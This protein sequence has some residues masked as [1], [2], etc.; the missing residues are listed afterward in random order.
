MRLNKVKKLYG[1]EFLK[2]IEY[3]AGT[4]FVEDFKKTYYWQKVRTAIFDEDFY[5][6]DY[7][8]NK[9][10]LRLTFSLYLICILLFHL[11]A[12]IKWMFTGSYNYDEKSFFVKKM[13][14]W[15]RYC[16]FNII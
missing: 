7:P 4:Q 14:V 10:K 6:R 8:K 2:K 9:P 3:S 13:I 11:F 16:R 5:I 12:A 1:D 15:D